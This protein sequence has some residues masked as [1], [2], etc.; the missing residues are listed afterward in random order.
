MQSAIE[1]TEYFRITAKKV[2]SILNKTSTDTKDLIRQLHALG[3]S[4]NDI[5]KAVKVTQ[6][7]VSKI[8][9]Q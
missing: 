4:Q 1:L 5:A 7:Y 6:Q 3:N 9:K 8:L 2:Y